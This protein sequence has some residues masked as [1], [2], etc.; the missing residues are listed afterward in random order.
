MVY[1]H[2]PGSIPASLGVR[3]SWAI[4]HTWWSEEI[5]A[6]DCYVA[7]FGEVFPKGK[8]EEKPYVLRYAE[9][10]LTVLD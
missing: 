10:S 4:A 5:H 9:S 7:F 8:P 2:D 6:M 3:Y 1:E